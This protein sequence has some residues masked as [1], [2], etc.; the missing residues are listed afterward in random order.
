MLN[1]RMRDDELIEGMKKGDRK[2][3]AKMLS[4]CENF[5][6]K[7]NSL[8]KEM[9]KS[10]AHV[11]GLTGSP[12]VGKSTLMNSIL[13]K[14]S[15]KQVGV[16]V[17]DPSSPF[18]HGA[19]L[20]DRIRMQSHATA[21]NIFIRS[22]ASRGA[23]G[24]LSPSI[25]EAC[26]AFEAFGMD[27]VIIETVGVGQSEVDVKNVADTVAV[28]L[29]P[30]GGDEVQMM[31]AGLMEI[32]DIFIINKSDNPKAQMLMSKLKAIMAMGN[33][34]IPIFLTNAITGEGVSEVVKAFDERFHEMETTNLLF[35]KRKA[36]L[37]HHVKASLRRELDE[38]VEKSE[39][40]D[41]KNDFLKLK[42]FFVNELCKKYK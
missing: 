8:L 16:I 4:L 24:G 3:L 18:T 11:I 26:D 7:A 10:T 39:I 12:G 37:V 22:F 14:L 15:T 33:K 20:G 41:D 23:L 27:D 25:Y 35:E 28:V 5:P 29:S 19:L 2:A 17:V 32:A 30:D 42:N 36:R 13:D 21:E 34:T 31:K 1:I 9:K 40:K 6:E 38:L